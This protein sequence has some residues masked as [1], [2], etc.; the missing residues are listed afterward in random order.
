M[1]PSGPGWFDV[2]PMTVH[3]SACDGVR[4]PNN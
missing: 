3:F 1:K 4:I 2:S